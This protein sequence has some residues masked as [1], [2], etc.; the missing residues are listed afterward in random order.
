MCFDSPWGHKAQAVKTY[1]E[2]DN[3]TT[4]KNF[5]SKL[6]VSLDGPDMFVGVEIEIQSSL[7]D[8]TQQNK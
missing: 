8:T 2:L 6:N 3:N 4:V 7:S 5:Q 1:L